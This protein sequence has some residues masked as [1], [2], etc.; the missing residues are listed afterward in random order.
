MRNNSSI[1]LT[2]LFLSGVL[3]SEVSYADKISIDELKIYSGY[4]SREGNDA[5]MA[6]TTGN[7]TYIKFYPGKRFIR[8]YI[9]YPYSKTVTAA[10]INAVFN[11]AAKK[12]KGSA[13][14]R[15]KFNI[16]EQQ[17][18]V[19]LDFYHWVNEQVMFDCSKPTPCKVTFADDSMTVIKPGIVLEHKIHYSLV[20]E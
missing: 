5:K 11:A 6:K 7:N 8:L 2:F 3:L 13:Y 12:T 18:V 4:Y 15:D 10:T 1:M 16:M 19:H 9:P 17:V 14:I 20:S